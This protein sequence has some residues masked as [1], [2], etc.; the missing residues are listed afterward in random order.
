[1]WPAIHSV[2]SGYRELT[3]SCE[4]EV[5]QMFTVILIVLNQCSNQLTRAWK[6]CKLVPCSTL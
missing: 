4:V 6:W 2:M 5:R 3:F 1:M